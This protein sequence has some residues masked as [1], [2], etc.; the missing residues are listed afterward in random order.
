MGCSAFEASQL[1]WGQGLLVGL[2]S[3]AFSLA[4]P[5]LCYVHQGGFAAFLRHATMSDAHPFPNRLGFF[6]ML[7]PQT[8]AAISAALLWPLRRRSR[9]LFESWI[10]AVLLWVNA[11][12][13]GLRY[14]NGSNESNLRW[15]HN[16]AV[17]YPLMCFSRQL[18]QLCMF[19]LLYKRAASIQRSGS[20]SCIFWLM[21]TS[22]GAATIWLVSFN[23]DRNLGLMGGSPHHHVAVWII[24]ASS[25]TDRFARFLATGWCLCI[26]WSPLR[27]FRIASDA[28]GSKVLHHMSWALQEGRLQ[29]SG[30]LLCCASHVVDEA[31]RLWVLKL[32]LMGS[33]AA[34][35][36]KVAEHIMVFHIWA[37]AVNLILQ[38]IGAFLLS[39]AGSAGEYDWEPRR[40]KP[41]QAEAMVEPWAHH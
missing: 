38:S 23:W 2:L 4:I 29:F 19:R 21:A 6:L 32:H 7:V 40:A 13:C 8:L 41:V 36:S 20:M 30:A 3:V 26:L 31:A 27:E 17:L 33:P 25:Y 11:L 9:H 18:A 28:L 22:V 35:Q 10:Y 5:S 24:N 14:V 37:R 16:D 34:K 12:I 1:R 39:G 15:A